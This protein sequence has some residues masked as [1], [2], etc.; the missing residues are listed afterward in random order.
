MG[1]SKRDNN[2]SGVE[3]LLILNLPYC[4]HCLTFS[5]S[6]NIGERKRWSNAGTTSSA[7]KSC[8]PTVL[9]ALGCMSCI[10]TWIGC[11][12]WQFILLPGCIRWVKG[13]ACDLRGMQAAHGKKILSKEPIK[14]PTTTV[15]ATAPQKSSHLPPWE[16]KACALTSI[17]SQFHQGNQ[18]WEP[19]VVHQEPPAASQMR[20]KGWLKRRHPLFKVSPGLQWWASLPKQRW[21]YSI[22]THVASNN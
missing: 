6:L 14:W 2:V 16:D 20:L 8:W 21:Q 5:Y 22:N 18:H 9:S 1:V 12:L 3:R 17:V 15:K 11:L 13:S 10:C 19:S 4:W 7:P